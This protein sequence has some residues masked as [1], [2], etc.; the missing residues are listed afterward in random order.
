MVA[1]SGWKKKFRFKKKLTSLDSSTID[2]C[3][4]LFDWAKF[5]ER[6]ERLSGEVAFAAG[7]CDPNEHAFGQHL[8]NLLA[9][10]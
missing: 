9:E 4:S 2:L 6:K 7:F 10:L 3:V 1:P 5:R 8:K